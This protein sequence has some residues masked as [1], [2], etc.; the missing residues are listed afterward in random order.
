VT[1]VVSL[2]AERYLQGTDVKPWAAKLKL[3]A[4]HAVH[5]PALVAVARNDP[6]VSVRE[7]KRV[8]A[9]LGSKVKRLELLPATAGH[10]WDMLTSSSGGWTSFERTLTAF[11][12]AHVR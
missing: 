8:Y 4:A 10:G 9:G 1:A 12:R 6:Y 7:S 3:A 2:S 5:Q 11:L